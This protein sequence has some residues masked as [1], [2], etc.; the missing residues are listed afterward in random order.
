MHKR[1]NF[2]I[3]MGLIIM[4]VGLVA[5][6]T[7]ITSSAATTTTLKPVADAHANANYPTTNFGTGTAIKADASPVIV[8]YL[9]F[10]VSGLSGITSAKLR[11]YVNTASPQGIT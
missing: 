8:S 11:I 1:K 10:N 6:F 3:R 2:L 7:L 9:R 4:V 5:S